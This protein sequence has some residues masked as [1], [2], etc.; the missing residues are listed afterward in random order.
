MI[1]MLAFSR[2]YTKY[3]L[4]ESPDTRVVLILL[5]VSMVGEWRS[6]TTEKLSGKKI[7]TSG[8]QK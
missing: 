7:I 6:L 1:V 2:L 8:M 4:E 5:P 3:S